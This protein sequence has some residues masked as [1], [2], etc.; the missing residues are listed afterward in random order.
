ME[1]MGDLSDAIK[2]DLKLILKSNA[3]KKFYHSELRLVPPYDFRQQT[4]HYN[5]KVKSCI[6]SHDQYTAQVSTGDLDIE[7]IDNEL[8]DRNSITIR[9]LILQMKHSNGTPIFLAVEKRWNGQGYSVLYPTVFKKEAME[10][11]KHLPFYMVKLYGAD[12]KREFNSRVQ[13]EIGA[14]TWNESENRAFSPDDLEL[15]EAQAAHKAMAWFSFDPNL[16]SDGLDPLTAG[17]TELDKTEQNDDIHINIEQRSEVSSFATTATGAAKKKRREPRFMSEQD[18]VSAVTT[19]TY[20]TRMTTLETQMDEIQVSLE[21]KM[22]QNAKSIQNNIQIQLEASMSAILSQMKVVQKTSP[23]SL[24]DSTMSGRSQSS[25]SAGSKRRT[26]GNSDSGSTQ[27]AKRRVHR[28]VSKETSSSKSTQKPPH[29]N[30][31]E[32]ITSSQTDKNI[33]LKS[34]D[35]S[36]VTQPKLTPPTYKEVTT[37][38]KKENEVPLKP[39]EEHASSGTT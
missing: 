25:H 15:S 11:I 17:I 21:R 26:G 28:N 22:E 3:I 9:E 8:V 5:N 27:S 20:D 16:S 29:I 34:I 7:N 23:E 6:M 13:Q 32:A 30:K 37:S 39:G 24:V 14:T 18:D 33:Q 4:T 10:Y 31:K 36:L 1:T 38:T 19:G 2:R 35:T 12:L